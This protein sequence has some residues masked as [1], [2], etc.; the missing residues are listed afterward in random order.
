MNSKILKPEQSMYKDF[1][2]IINEKY[3]LVPL[4]KIENDNIKELFEKGRGMYICNFP[5]KAWYEYHGFTQ[6]A[7][8]GIEKK[9][10]FLALMDK[11]AMILSPTQDSRI[12]SSSKSIKV[13]SVI[14]F[15]SRF[16]GRFAQIS[17]AFQ[18][19]KWLLIN[20]KIYDYCLFNNFSPGE[21]PSMFVAKYLLNKRILID[22]EDDYLKQSRNKIYPY[23]FK[24]AK[25]LP[26]A[27]IC[28]NRDMTRYF[29][30]KKVYVFNGF[31]DLSYV[32]TV[33]FNL[34]EGSK[35][36]Y[37]GTLDEIR[38]V[39]LIPDIVKAVREKLKSF[40]INITG[41]GFLE[42]EVRLW[43]FEE[44][45]YLG[46]L[47]PENYSKVLSKTD[48]FLVLQKPDHPFS[49]GSFPSKVEFYS[50]YK[51]PIYRLILN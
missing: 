41:S 21:L 48:I 43:N 40:T 13:G 10:K 46:F 9:E 42:S 35:F 18:I 14:H 38:G 16:T 29:S 20:R 17:M 2:I 36:L 31:I 39:D 3:C 19:V 44:V 11:N 26:D 25:S 49:R 23:Y 24:I 51:K 30:Q 5:D 50:K 27:I 1:R 4:L 8:Y 33:D 45:K 7:N 47:S 6:S 32:N 37:A 28:I 22:F 34:R 15:G 12:I